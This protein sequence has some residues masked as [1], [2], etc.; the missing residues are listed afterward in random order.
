MRVLSKQ[1]WD[2]WNENGYVV[3]HNAV[4]QANLDATVDAIWEFLEIDCDNPEDWYRYKPYTHANKCSPI[5]AAGMVEIYQ[6]QTL[7]DNRQYPKVHQAF[8]EIWGTEE[9]WVS[10][11]RAN[12]KPPARAD[13]PDWQ[14]RG[15]IHWDTDTSVGKVPFGVQGCCI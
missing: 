14:S 7:W 13:K 8:S 15:M 4:P 5:S 2:F 10:L 3:V 6:H 11:D 12:M 9:L 1:D